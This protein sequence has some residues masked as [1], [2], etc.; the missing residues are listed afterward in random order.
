MLPYCDEIIL[1][2]LENLGDPSIHRSVKPQILSAFGDIA[3]SIG[4]EFAKYFDV[5]MQMLLQVNT[6]LP[7]LKIDDYLVSIFGNHCVC[8]RPAMLKW[9]ALIMTWWST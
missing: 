4:S 8:F 2:L 7:E 6:K 5:V 1:L 3:L 9:T